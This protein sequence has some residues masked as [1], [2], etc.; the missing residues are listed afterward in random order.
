MVLILISLLFIILCTLTFFPALRLFYARNPPLAIMLLTLPACFLGVYLAMELSQFSE[1]QDRRARAATLMEM[2]KENLSTKE[3]TKLLNSGVVLEQISPLSLKVLL[4][5]QVNMKKELS[6]L[7][8]ATG[9]NRRDHLNGFTREL[10]FAQG[11]LTAEAEF[12]RGNIG[13][14]DLADIL[15]AWIAKKDLPST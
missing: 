15:T 14:R 9:R 8:T 12:Q 6:F 3:L 11:V 5:S 7:T 4:S 2:T 13:R 1:R 10:T